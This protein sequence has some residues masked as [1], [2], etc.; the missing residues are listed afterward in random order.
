M[1]DALAGGMV[2]RNAAAIGQAGGLLAVS[3]GAYV[4]LLDMAQHAAEMTAGAV[5]GAS[6]VY[7]V[8]RGFPAARVWAEE[9][10]GGVGE[11]QRPPPPSPAP[12]A[13]C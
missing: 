11:G 1:Q 13:C 8:R 6:A 9:G 3:R 12:R 7:H 5:V 4:G 2:H 10:L